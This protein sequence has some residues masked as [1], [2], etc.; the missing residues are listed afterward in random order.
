MDCPRRVQPARPTF[1]L[2]TSSRKSL[3]LLS[4]NLYLLGRFL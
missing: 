1:V 3:F 2:Q 4:K